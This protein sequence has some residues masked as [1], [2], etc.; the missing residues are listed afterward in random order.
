M[1]KDKS[2]D[3]QR[4]ESLGRVS[5]NNRATVNP[6]TIKDNEVMLPKTRAEQDALSI[7]VNLD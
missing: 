5:G 4:S 3:V 1:S 6:A 7:R 2:L